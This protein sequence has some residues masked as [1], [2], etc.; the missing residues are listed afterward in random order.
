ME[1]DCV[2]VGV[3]GEPQERLQSAFRG[4]KKGVQ[5]FGLNVAYFLQESAFFLEKRIIKKKRTE[6]KNSATPEKKWL[7][8]LA[9]FIEVHWLN[10]FEIFDAKR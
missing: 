5:V 8:T 2:V 3:Y 1:T 6:K 9:E 4:S 10:S 7:D